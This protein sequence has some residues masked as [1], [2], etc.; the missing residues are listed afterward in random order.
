MSIGG[1]GVAVA[2]LSVATTG[3]IVVLAPPPPPLRMS[4]AEALAALHHPSP[5]FER[6]VAG[7]PLPGTRVP[8]LEGL[9]AV[10]LHRAPRSVTVTL[11]E[12]E[13]QVGIRAR[14]KG[15]SAPFPEDSIAGETV[16]FRQHGKG[17]FDMIDP[18]KEPDAYRKSALGLLRPG[19][20][21]SVLRKDGKW[22]NVQ[23]V[24]PFLTGWQRNIVMSLAITLLLLIPL[25][26]I[27]ARRLTRPF[28]AL[29]SSLGD[30]ADAVP[31]EGPRELREAAAAIGAMRKRLATEAAE[32]ARMLTAIAHDLRTPMTGL[33]LRVEAAPEPQRT[34]MIADI[35]RMQAMIGEV[36]TFARD[37]AAQP[38]LLNIKPVLADIVQEMQG[39]GSSSCLVHGEDA[40]VSAPPLA[41]RRAIENLLQNAIDYA[42]GGVVSVERTAASVCISVSDDGPGIPLVDRERLL[43]PFERGDASRNRDTGGAGLGLSIVRDFAARNR[44]SFRLAEATS[45]GTLAILQLPAA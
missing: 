43:R 2:I 4:A 16:I 25:A 44:G 21:L 19:F 17:L 15:F 40:L 31:E 24:R 20:A 30:S 7:E 18:R 12:K 27:F 39:R 41:F 45:G 35:E 32:R 5:E 36:L 10:E 9:I 3:T 1:F 38:E 37:A 8:Q 34:R 23:P 14:E 26:W 22:L 13:E 42:G 28:R 33:R 29:A 11:L 6:E